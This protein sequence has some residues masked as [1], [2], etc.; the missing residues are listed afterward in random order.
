MLDPLD[1]TKDGCWKKAKKRG[2]GS[3]WNSSDNQSDNPTT[4]TCSGISTSTCIN[5]ESLPWFEVL[6]GASF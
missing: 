1:Q 3:G 4:Q 5:T 6:R 2:V